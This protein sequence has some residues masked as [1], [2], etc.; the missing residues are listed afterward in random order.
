[1]P[2]HHLIALLAMTLGL[3]FLI[4]LALVYSGSGA[5]TDILTAVLAIVVFSTFLMLMVFEIKR[6]ADLPSD[7]P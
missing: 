2:L 1:M 3:P 7:E 4:L 6:L 5:S